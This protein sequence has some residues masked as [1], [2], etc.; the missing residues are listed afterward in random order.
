MP[1]VPY[2]IFIPEA[3]FMPFFP[4]YRHRL[5]CDIAVSLPSVHGA[6]TG[7]PVAKLLTTH[8]NISRH[9]RRVFLDDE[10]V[11][12]YYFLAQKRRTRPRSMLLLPVMGDDEASLYGAT[13]G[14]WR[15]RPA[16]APDLAPNTHPHPR[17]LSYSTSGRLA[18]W[19]RAAPPADGNGSDGR[20][21]GRGIRLLPGMLRQWHQGRVDSSSARGG[22]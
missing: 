16:R 14:F 6:A 20:E 8:R 15:E 19:S 2:A 7:R 10:F 18:T 17:P 1:T 11:N 22:S 5:D 21:P 4:R 9:P 3:V 12:V 13:A